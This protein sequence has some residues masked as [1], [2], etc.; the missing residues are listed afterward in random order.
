MLLARQYCTHPRGAEAILRRYVFCAHCD[1]ETEVAPAMPKA[2]A[3]RQSLEGRPVLELCECLNCGHQFTRL[4][5]AG[6]E[7]V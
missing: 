3:C 6:G 5:D 1:K 7:D 4:Q 2:C